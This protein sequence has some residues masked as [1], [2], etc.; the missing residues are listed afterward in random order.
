V[1]LLIILLPRL[2]YN[3]I[4]PC[5]PIYGIYIPLRF[6]GDPRIRAMFPIFVIVVPLARVHMHAWSSCCHSKSQA[7]L[8]KG[9]GLPDCFT[10]SKVLR[11]TKNIAIIVRE[12]V[13]VGL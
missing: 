1:S 13:A 7:A 12:G 10:L 2:Q 5:R 11:G 4:P 8:G 6:K 9:A 3:E